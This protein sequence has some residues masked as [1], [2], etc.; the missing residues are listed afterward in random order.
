[1]VFP[2]QMCFG[3]WVELLQKYNRGITL[4]IAKKVI[5][6]IDRSINDSDNLNSAA[7]NDLMGLRQ[8]IEG[9]GMYNE[10]G[11]TRRIGIINVNNNY[12]QYNTGYPYLEG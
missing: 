10:Y 2:A 6:Y 11:D 4:N 8:N 7:I 5:N 9:W 3:Y 1:M 12:G